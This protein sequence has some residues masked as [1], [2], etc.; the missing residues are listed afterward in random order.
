MV[1][2]MTIPAAELLLNHQRIYVLADL[3]TLSHAAAA[4]IVKLAAN[5]IA[6]QGVFNLALAGGSTP[7]QLYMTLATPPYAQQIAWRN[8]HV[9]FGDERN[10]APDHADSNF[11]MARQSLLEKVPIPSEQIHAIPTQCPDMQACADQYAQQLARLPHRNGIPCFDLIL[12]GMGNDGHTASLFPDT[13]ILQE[14]A[15]AVAAVYVPKLDTW[16]VSL[17]YPV[18]NQA[19]QVMILACGTDKAEV[20]TNVFNQPACNYPIQQLCNAH[21]E[22]YVD[23]AAAAGLRQ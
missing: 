19:R 12:L 13:A 15:R 16:R 7:R 18:L 17:T 1:Q 3:V 4:Q 14:T 20:L 5:A 2:Q 8:V 9:Y 11:R 6:E 21:T 10:V 22:W 23:I